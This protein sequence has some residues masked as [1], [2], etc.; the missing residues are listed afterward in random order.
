MEISNEKN[1]LSIGKQV[2]L[3]ILI[4]L[5]QLVGVIFS[6]NAMGLAERV[7]SKQ[8]VLLLFSLLCMFFMGWKKNNNYSKNIRLFVIL[9][10]CIAVS[11]FLRLDFSNAINAIAILGAFIFLF[12]CF[13]RYRN[14]IHIISVL[15]SVGTL[16][17]VAI[18][19]IRYGIVSINSQGVLLTM[20][21]I[22][23]LN[24]MCLSK[25]KS[26]ILFLTWITMVVSALAIT[27]SRTSMLAFMIIAVI[28]YYYLYIK[29]LTLKNVIIVIAGVVVIFVFYENLS[30]FLETVFF[31]KWGNRDITSG[32]T[33][34]WKGILKSA[35]IIGYGPAHIY[36]I[37]GMIAKDAHNSFLQVLGAYGIVA[38][39][40]LAGMFIS[41][42]KRLKKVPN[43]IQYT[44]FFI[45]WF[46]LSMFE[47]LDFISSRI[48]P[49]SFLFVINL[50]L[51]AIENSRGYDGEEN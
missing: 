47:N 3:F 32:R 40:L 45:G 43:S 33:D 10:I 39:L 27:R 4:V 6:L 14:S 36:Q 34:I 24:L 18:S 15:A 46:V 20:C 49:L 8:I 5:V 29:K 50:C 17:A 25:R 21:G 42:I 16:V 31:N 48:L 44:N 12:S 28:S 23:G 26:I 51:M 30:S 41:T 19:I 38:F 11:S 37:T 13:N 22:L 1:K 9:C 7:N 35:S 2:L